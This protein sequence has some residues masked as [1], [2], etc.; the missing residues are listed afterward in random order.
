M[1]PPIRIQVKFPNEKEISMTQNTQHEDTGRAT[2][3]SKGN[4][5]GHWARVAVMFMSGGFVF[6]HAMSEDDDIAKDDADKGA[7]VKKQ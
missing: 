7:K 6:P 4:R 2:T 1:H 5:I 3:Y